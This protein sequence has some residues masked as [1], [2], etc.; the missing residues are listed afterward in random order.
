MT[1]AV[2]QV[3]SQGAEQ[4]TIL[5]CLSHLPIPGR[6]LDIG[7]YHPTVF[8]NTRALYELGWSGVMVEP[9]PEPFLSLLKEYGNDERITLISAAVGFHKGLSV[10]HATADALSTTEIDH[11]EKWR[12]VAKYDGRFHVPTIT[13]GDILNQFGAFEFVSIDTEGTSAGLFK[14]L[15]RSGMLPFVICVEHDNHETE[16][17]ELAGPLGY[18]LMLRTGENC[19][20]AR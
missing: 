15:L 9:A 14:E 19:V 3:Y 4:H 13:I 17:A 20:F 10:L 11:V 16:L 12:G 5:K 18:R 1:P 2:E 7:A 6:F 8:S